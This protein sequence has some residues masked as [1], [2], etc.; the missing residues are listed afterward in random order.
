MLYCT[1]VQDW[2][3][4]D[5]SVHPDAWGAQTFAADGSRTGVYSAAHAHVAGFCRLLQIDDLCIVT[6]LRK[7]T[8]Y[9][10]VQQQPY[11]KHCRANGKVAT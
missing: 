2:L 10:G 4:V 3:I 8:M 1:V 11:R 7:S 5:L 6:Q 9:Q